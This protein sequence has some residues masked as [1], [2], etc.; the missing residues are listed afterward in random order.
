MTL[1]L[2]VDRTVADAF[3]SVAVQNPWVVDVGEVLAFAL[4]P[5]VFRVAVTG[6][7]VL[8]WRH[9]RRRTALACG[10]TMVVGSLLGVVLKL[11]VARPRPS[12]G[13]PVAA[14]IGYSMPSGHAL[15]AALGCGLLLVLAWPVLRRPGT[16]M[17][18]VAAAA[19]VTG[20]TALDRMVLGVHYLS[21]VTVGVGLGAALTL[22]AHRLTSRQNGGL[23]PA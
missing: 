4:H 3:Y 1:V 9:G 21:D 19:V 5:W 23:G 6:A 20:V 11:V 15:N 2:G 10:A 8:A 7:C 14:E 16:R 22:V 18:A 17:A 12:W 13:D